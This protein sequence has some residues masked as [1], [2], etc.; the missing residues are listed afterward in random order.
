MMQKRIGGR[1]NIVR[2]VSFRG[3][4][5]EALCLRSAEVHVYTWS[6]QSITG[7]DDSKKCSVSDLDTMQ[8]NKP[9]H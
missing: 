6:H 8:S 5:S 3:K 4:L 2:R 7:I 1:Y 9:M